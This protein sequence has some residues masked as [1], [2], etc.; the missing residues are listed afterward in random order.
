VDNPLCIDWEKESIK[1]ISV[2]KLVEVVNLIGLVSSLKRSREV[3]TKIPA[4]SICKLS[5]A[6]AVHTKDHASSDH[7]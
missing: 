4:L 7:K 5:R 3:D 1:S 2:F 6:C